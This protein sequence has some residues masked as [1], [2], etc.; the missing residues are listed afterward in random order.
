MAFFKDLVEHP[1]SFSGFNMLLC[2]RTQRAHRP[3][4]DVRNSWQS[5]EKLLA[6]NVS[7]AREL[8]AKKVIAASTASL[9]VVLFGKLL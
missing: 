9:V 3:Q 5:D 8:P 7:S 1:L 6:R 2:I 4:A